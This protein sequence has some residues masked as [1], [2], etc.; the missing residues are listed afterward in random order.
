MIITILCL[1]AFNH[2][3]PISHLPSPKFQ[4]NP[5]SSGIIE[6]YFT[7]DALAA[8]AFGTVLASS[9]IDKEGLKHPKHV[10]KTMISASII[11]GAC[12]ALIYFCL[13]WIGSAMYRPEGFE[14][15]AQLLSTAATGLMGRWGQFAIW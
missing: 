14:N 6:G 8:L 3:S 15:G 11:A 10:V 13:A 7:M 1:L 5:L 12:L 2:L 4:E 9:I